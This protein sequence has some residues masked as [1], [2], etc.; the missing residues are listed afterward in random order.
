MTTKSFPRMG[1]SHLRKAVREIVEA[2]RFGGPLS[3]EEL[4]AE[5]ERINEEHEAQVFI[6]Q[7]DEYPSLHFLSA[8]DRSLQVIAPNEN[9][10]FELTENGKRLV[11]SR[12]FDQALFDLLEERSRTH[13]TDYHEILE[14][15]SRRVENNRLELGTPR[16]REFE[17][18]LTNPNS[19]SA[20]LSANFLEEFEIIYRDGRTWTI[21]A[22]RYAELQ[23]DD[24]EM[25][26][27]VLEHNGGRMAN[28]EFRAHLQEELGWDESRIDDAITTL[29]DKRRIEHQRAEGTNWITSKG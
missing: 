12:D 22:E 24:E 4:L 13:F 9:G 25:A 8:E 3:Q 29:E 18:M 16:N 6:K 28:N 20:S 27:G 17:S 21:D 11:N 23:R 19:F 15:I 5:M 7:N 2:I 26:I 10:D 14:S 1:K